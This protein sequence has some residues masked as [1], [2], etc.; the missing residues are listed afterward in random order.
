MLLNTEKRKVMLKVSVLVHVNKTACVYRAALVEGPCVLS[1][2]SSLILVF[3][4]ITLQA[5]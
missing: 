4:K 3:A 1:G 2:A 5:V